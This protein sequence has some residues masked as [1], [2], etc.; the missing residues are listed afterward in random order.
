MIIYRYLIRQY[1]QILF[2]S[3]VALITVFIIVNMIENLDEFL[4]NNATREIIIR[5]YWNFIPEVIR[6]VTPISVLI[7]VLFSLGRLSSLNEITALKSGGLSLYQLIVPYIILNIIFS[8]GLLYFNGWVVPKANEHRFAIER[9]YLKKEVETRSVYNFFFRDEP[10]RNV[11]FQY[12]DPDEL[13]GQYIFIEEFNSVS[14][15]RIVKRVEAKNFRWDV[16]LNTWV[17]YYVL[18]RDF[19]GGN[20][21][22]VSYDSLRVDLRIKHNQLMKLQR[23][24]EEMNFDEVREYLSLLSQGGKDVRRQMIK[25]YAGYA[26]PFSCL[27]LVLFAVPFASIKR[28][29][30]IALQI[31]SAMAFSF[32]YLFFTEIGQIL[33]YT[34]T[35][36]PAIGGWIANIIFAI[37][38][39]AVLLRTRT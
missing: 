39:I 16:K 35:L 7:G 37:F 28:R 6:L 30:G 36:H 19:V 29:G 12:Y 4:D 21:K 13:R 11:S 23:K 27:I 38:G 24:I 2:F 33:V 31:A 5:Y 26:F 32:L 9:K 20:A 14:N 17:L 18:E 8:V 1:L 34:T 22:L 15:P 10:T 25:Y 3:L